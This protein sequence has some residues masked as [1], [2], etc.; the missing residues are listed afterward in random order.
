MSLVN[1]VQCLGYLIVPA[2][3][4]VAGPLRSGAHPAVRPIGTNG[5]GYMTSGDRARESAGTTV[6]GKPSGACSWPVTPSVWTASEV[7]A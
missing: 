1:G 3:I 4:P 7:D 6:C 5:T 2:P